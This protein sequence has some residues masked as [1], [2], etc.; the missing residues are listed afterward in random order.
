LLGCSSVYIPYYL[1]PSVRKFLSSKGI[2]VKSY[3]ISEEFEPSGIQQ[4]PDSAILIVNFFGIISNTFL[5][6]S[7][8]KFKNIIIDNCP[9]FYNDPLDGC[10]NI[11]SPRKFFGVPDGCYVI[12]ENAERFLD[13]YDQ[14]F[15][16]GTSS[17]L[18]KRIEYGSDAIYHERMKN[19][20]RIDNSD[21]LK[22]SIL[23][24]ALLNNIDYSIIKSKRQENFKI[25]HDLYKK[26]NRIDPIRFMDDK[27]VPMVYPLVI[28]D[29][30]LAVKLKLKGI[31]TGRW[32]TSVLSEVPEKSF[33]AWLSQNLLP[34]PIDQRYNSNELLD[35]YQILRDL[36]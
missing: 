13:G 33:E 7:F 20:E 3:F 17:F 2:I 14:D 25:A 21:V 31:Y 6:R 27:S 15:S 16:S 24:K 1:C 10:L 4:E 34:M 22:M 12:G 11:Y 5:K 26:L 29:K 30:E 19:E 18:M 32:W 9:A 8:L 23:T 35:C 36:I 28:E